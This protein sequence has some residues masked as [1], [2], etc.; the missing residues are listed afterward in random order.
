MGK[1]TITLREWLDA[2]RSGDWTQGKGRLKEVDGTVV[3][4]C[5]LGV[6]TALTC[7]F[8]INPFGRYRSRKSQSTALP[9]KFLSDL[10]EGMWVSGST[11]TEFNILAY[12]GPG[13]DYKGKSVARL[14]D[15]RK[16]FDE[17]ADLVEAEARRNG[18]NG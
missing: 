9:H 5:C 13:V 12:S 18:W 7:G 15:K 17:I 4:H 11:D 1:L 3:R 8:D 14:N 6:G 10:P 2:L 16:S